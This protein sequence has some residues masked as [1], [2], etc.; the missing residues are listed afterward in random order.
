MTQPEAA[1]VLV[2]RVAEKLLEDYAREYQADHLTWRDFE[3]D[4][5]ALV[6][7]MYDWLDERLRALPHGQ[8]NLFRLGFDAAVRAVRDE[9]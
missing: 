4:A 5:R 2:Q 8:G 3:R 6:G 9:T 7:V 1:S